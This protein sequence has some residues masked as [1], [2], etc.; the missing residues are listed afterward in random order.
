MM[1]IQHNPLFDTEKVTKLYSEKDG[2]PVT[3]VCTTEIVPGNLIPVDVFFRETPHPKFGNR[4]FGLYESILNGNLMITNADVVEDFNFACVPDSS[5]VLHYSRDR[6]DYVT[7][8]AG[9]MVDGGRAY[10]RTNS[11]AVFTYTVKD[12]IMVP[13]NETTEE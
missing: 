9:N 1:I 7:T 5:G 12:G 6:H 8:D 10:V 11:F 3:Y 13:F 4:Y 2:V